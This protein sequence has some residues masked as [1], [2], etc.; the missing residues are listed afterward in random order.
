MIASK[1]SL[2]IVQN[3]GQDLVQSYG[4]LSVG[5]FTALS[6]GFSGWMNCNS[7]FRQMLIDSLVS[8]SWWGSLW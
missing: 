1:F 6:P 7:I 5:H 4:R 8:T 3:G 2:V